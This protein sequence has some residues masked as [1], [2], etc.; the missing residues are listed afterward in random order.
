MANP[1]RGAVKLLAAGTT[2]NLSFSVNA[3]CELEE[4]LDKPIAEII[5]SIQKPDQLRMVSVRALVWAALRDHHEDLAIKEA[6][7]IVT[8]AGF[9]VAI[10][11]VGEAI[12]LAFPEA[13]GKANPRKAAAGD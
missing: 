13:K 4:E 1:N 3:I 12:R 6:G 10:E 7:L 8:D 5:A 2:Y 9:Q 11:K